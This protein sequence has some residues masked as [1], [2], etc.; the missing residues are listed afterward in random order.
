MGLKWEAP[1]VYL[2][3]GP[4]DMR[5]QINSLAA[6][7]QGTLGR[8]PFGGELFAFCNRRGTLIKVLY[9]DRTGFCMWQKRLEEHRFVWPR[10]QA[11][12]LA[13]GVR[14]LEW[15]LEGLDIR[16]AHEELEY[17]TVV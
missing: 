10:E 4:T 6:L 8:N 13:V 1:A 9:W 14:E 2:A 17:R 5:K 16:G 15:L 3:M 12:V 11:E 7:V